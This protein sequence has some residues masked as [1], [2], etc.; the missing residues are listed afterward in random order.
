MEKDGEH[1]HQK[2]NSDKN[3]VLKTKYAYNSM[4]T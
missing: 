4:K 2:T 1:H 3:L